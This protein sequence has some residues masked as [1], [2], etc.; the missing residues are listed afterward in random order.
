MAK[1]WMNLLDQE[2][3]QDNTNTAVASRE[4]PEVG[5]QPCGEISENGHT[6]EQGTDKNTE[7]AKKK[8]KKKLTPEEIYGH[9]VEL[10]SEWSG[11]VIDD[12]TA[13]ECLKWAELLDEVEIDIETYG[14]LKRD[15]LLY[16]RCQIRLIIL[17]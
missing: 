5:S 7:K 2:L 6:R 4:V 13:Q 10:A 15:G 1:K 9:T 11:Y 3:G 8:A 12:V 14:P 16:T 17:H